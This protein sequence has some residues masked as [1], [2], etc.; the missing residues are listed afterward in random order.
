MKP[1]PE[2]AW[3]AWSPTKLVSRLGYVNADWYVAGG[4]ALDLWHGHQTRAH[5]DLEFVVRPENVE[6]CRKA[7]PD[8]EFF[9]AHA[10]TLTHL[11]STSAVPPDLWQMWGADMTSERWRVDM[12]IE[13]GTPDLWVYKRDQSIHWPR[14][15]AIR[16]SA[17]GI[18]YLAPPIVLLFKA[19]HCRKKDEH[20]FQAA[21]PHLASDEKADLYQ[22]LKLLHPGHH[23]IPALQPGSVNCNQGPQNRHPG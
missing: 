4:W 16:K 17:A 22:W 14:T 15:A 21:L 1:L 8:L 12:M 11:P 13:R 6:P 20:D 3:D 2:N 18:S 9:I 23:W 5:A 7:L 19:K 10:G